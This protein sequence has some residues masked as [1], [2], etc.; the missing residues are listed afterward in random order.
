MENMIVNQVKKL[1]IGAIKRNAEELNEKPENVAIWIYTE[2]NAGY[3]KLKLLH[4]Y[5]SIRDMTFSE[6]ATKGERITYMLMGFDIEKMTPEWINKFILRSAY[7]MGFNEV[8]IPKYMLAYVNNPTT[9]KSELHAMMYVN[10]RPIREIELEYI[11]ET[12]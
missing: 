3:P 7:D 6:L 9:N 12:R 10:N 11:L 1:I 2:N 4:N 5:K 8:S